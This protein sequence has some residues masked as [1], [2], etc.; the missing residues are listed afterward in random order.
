MDWSPGLP[1]GSQARPPSPF[2]ARALDGLV[3]PP[4]V[5]DTLALSP[6]QPVR[7]RELP[8][9]TQPHNQVL[10]GQQEELPVQLDAPEHPQLPGEVLPGEWPRRAGPRGSRW[11][12]GRVTSGQYVGRGWAAGHLSV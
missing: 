3:C 2:G 5:S 1:L 4:G 10:R 6:L 9:V 12:W 7:Y 8:G 11:G